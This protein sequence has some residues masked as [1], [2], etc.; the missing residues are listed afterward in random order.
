MPVPIAKIGELIRY[1]G[2]RLSVA[3]AF[4]VGCGVLIYL[5]ATNTVTELDDSIVELL[6]IGAVVVI[7]IALIGRTVTDMFGKRG[8]GEQPDPEDRSG[9]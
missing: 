4:A 9:E 7:A 2:A 8:S 1:L 3:I 6:V 5:D